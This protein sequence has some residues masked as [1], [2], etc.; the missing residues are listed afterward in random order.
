MDGG[1]RKGGRSCRRSG[2]RGGPR[3]R[4]RE[5]E[6]KRDKER[7]RERAR[8]RAR[9]RKRGQ[10]GV[11]VQG[12]PHVRLE[13]RD[14]FPAAPARGSEHLEAAVRCGRVCSLGVDPTI[15]TTTS[16]VDEARVEGEED[17]VRQEL[18]G[19][20]GLPLRSCAPLLHRSER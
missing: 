18:A 11:V 10:R 9:E 7:E 1:G 2:E 19:R 17:D 12:G 8:E 15:G 14:S 16:N 6:I 3:E 13:R 5:R 20:C 4:E